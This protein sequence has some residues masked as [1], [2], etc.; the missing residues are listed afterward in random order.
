MLSNNGIRQ[1]LLTEIHT[2]TGFADADMWH[3]YFVC[4]MR[5][6]G[7]YAVRDVVVD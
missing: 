5:L 4:C 6:R 2:W 7:G 3:D 1:L